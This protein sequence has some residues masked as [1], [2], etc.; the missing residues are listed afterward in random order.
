ML[1]CL[2]HA[3]SGAFEQ[4]KRKFADV[5]QTLETNENFKNMNKEFEAYCR[6]VIAKG[7]NSAFYDLD[8]SPQR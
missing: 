6:E 7:L 1:N 4:M 2:K 3:W 8:S 5:F